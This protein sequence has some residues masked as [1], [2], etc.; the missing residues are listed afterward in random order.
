MEN[1]LLESLIVLSVTA[2]VILKLIILVREMKSPIQ[3]QMYV[4]AYAV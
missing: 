1:V 2:N 4:V 3:I